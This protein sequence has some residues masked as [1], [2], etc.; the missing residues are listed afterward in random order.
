MLTR[1]SSPS[2][3][4]HTETISI[5]GDIPEQVAAYSAHALSIMIMMI[6]YEYHRPYRQHHHSNDRF[7]KHHLWYYHYHHYRNHLTSRHH[8]LYY[9]ITPWNK[10]KFWCRLTCIE[11]L[12]TTETKPLIFLP[13]FFVRE[14]AKHLNFS[15]NASKLVMSDQSRQK[16]IS[17]IFTCFRFKWIKTTSAKHL[18]F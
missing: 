13:A 1:P 7:Y 10:I 17:H 14:S 15:P 9:L 5:P 16:K 18:Y 11:W 6:I 8:C 4:V 12:I 2:R 3:P